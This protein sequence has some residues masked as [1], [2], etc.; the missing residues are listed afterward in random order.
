MVWR[1]LAIFQRFISIEVEFAYY[2]GDEALFK[3]SGRAIC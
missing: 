3:A 2:N 1:R